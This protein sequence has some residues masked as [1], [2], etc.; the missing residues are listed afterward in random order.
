MEAL[1]GINFNLNSREFLHTPLRIAKG[2]PDRIIIPTGTT[3]GNLPQGYNPPEYTA[4]VV[5]KNDETLDP[6]NPKL[7]ADPANLLEVK[8]PYISFEGSVK[9]DQDG[10]PLNPTGPTGIKGRGLLGKWGANFA[11]DPIITREKD[12]NLEVIVIAKE[13]GIRIP[14]GMNEKGENFLTTAVREAEEEVL[15]K[16]DPELAVLVYQGYVDDPRNT[17]HAWTELTGYLIHGHFDFEPKP[18]DDAEKAWWAKVD[19]KLIDSLDIRAQAFEL[20]S[21]LQVLQK[22]ERSFYQS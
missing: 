9:F 6:K 16:I 1:L 10:H 2:Y 4:P 19:Q 3:W 18:G 15:A 20:I 5:F 21:S 13:G 22:S 7:W 14:G 17:D 11:V 12:G 8:H